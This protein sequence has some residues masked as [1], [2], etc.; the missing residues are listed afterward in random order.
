MKKKIISSLLLSALLFLG[1]YGCDSNTE[2]GVGDYQ[3]KE[4]STEGISSLEI[5]DILTEKSET[6]TGVT[7]M[8]HVAEE[9]KIVLEAQES[10]LSQITVTQNASLLSVSAVGGKSYQTGYIKIDIY[11]SVF[12]EITLSD[13]IALTAEAGCFSGGTVTLR[14]K[15]ASAMTLEEVNAN[16]LIVQAE[17]ASDITLTAVSA[18]TTIVQLTKASRL[19]ATALNTVAL[20]IDAAAGSMATVTSSTEAVL[21]R[22][23]NA[24]RAVLVGN[25]G[26]LSLD[27]TDASFLQASKLDSINA[28]INM[29]TACQ[30]FISFTGMVEGSLSDTSTLTYSGVTENVLVSTDNTSSAKIAKK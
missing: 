10:I 28:S 30:A 25:T 5:F 7:V 21:V 1:L 16:T 24:S 3:T 22:L 19:T 6:G 26:Y 11:G 17:S 13:A 20:E 8:L 12:S 18:V 27:A 14:A 15:D 23:H 9:E 29:S 4:I 2:R